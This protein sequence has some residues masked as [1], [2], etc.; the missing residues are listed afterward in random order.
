MTI[1]QKLLEYYKKCLSELPNDF[2]SARNWVGETYIH[3]GV[4]YCAIVL[5]RGN[6]KNLNWTRKYETDTRG[7]WGPIPESAL[8]KEEIISSIQLR[9][10]ILSKIVNET[11]E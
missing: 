7:Y 2:I 11:N 10:E 1:Q 9:I 4:C 6:A 5:F 8:N 3:K